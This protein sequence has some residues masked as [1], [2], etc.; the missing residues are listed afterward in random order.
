MSRIDAIF[1][2]LRSSGHSALMPFLCAGHPPGASLGDL[3]SAAERGGASIVEVGIPFSDP[4]A[5]GPVIA[6]AMHGALGRG[7]TPE[8]IF[9]EVRS[10]RESLSIGLIAMVSASIVQGWGGPGAFVLAAREAGFDGLIVPDMPLEESEVVAQAAAANDLSLS[11]LIS[12][13]TPEGRIPS[14]V[15]ASTG[16]VYLMARMGITGES[17]DTPDIRQRV[18]VIRNAGDIP[19]A[20][21]F[22]ISTRE[23]VACVVDHADAAIV[24]S[25]LVRRQASADDPA[26]ETER[27][28]SELARGLIPGDSGAISERQ[29]ADG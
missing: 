23:Q 22:G 5:D 1:S 18:G 13:G 26:L 12:P 29:P 8:S 3:L 14:L 10:A 7:I 9:E 19:I 24:G 20:C 17:R 11:L 15:R 4:I 21:G 25:A 2:D 28:V 6:S 16:F 27:F